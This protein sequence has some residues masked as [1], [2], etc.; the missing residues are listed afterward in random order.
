ML[1]ALMPI[2][3][4]YDTWTSG[5]DVYSLCCYGFVYLLDSWEIVFE[6]PNRSSF[7]FT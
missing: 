7:T 2:G 4:M 3:G 6:K 5:S 1:L